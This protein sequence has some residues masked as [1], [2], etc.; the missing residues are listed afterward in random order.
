MLAQLILQ[1]KKLHVLAVALHEEKA[2][3][4]LISANCK[5]FPKECI[6]PKVIKSAA[7]LLFVFG[8]S[9][10]PGKSQH[11]ELIFHIRV[12]YPKD[13]RVSSQSMFGMLNGFTL[14]PGIS[15]QFTDISSIGM[16]N[17]LQRKTSSTSKHHLHNIIHDAKSITEN[18]KRIHQ[19][20][21]Q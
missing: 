11:Q 5:S 7:L 18:F 21:E 13:M 14:D 9:M 15:D 4:K 12:L 16:L 1:L 2:W 3:K 20:S 10:D 17:H 8:C 6:K 19:S